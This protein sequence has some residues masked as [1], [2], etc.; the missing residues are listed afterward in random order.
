MRA[1]NLVLVVLVLLASCAT[2]A[3][4][5]DEETAA[6]QRFKG[7]A[8]PSVSGSP[9]SFSEAVED[10][11]VADDE[12][13]FIWEVDDSPLTT[14][15]PS[16]SA[17]IR[18]TILRNARSYLDPSRYGLIEATSRG[19]ADFI[20]HVRVDT[21]TEYSGYSSID[22]GTRRYTYRLED[23]SRGVFIS[24]DTLRFEVAHNRR[25]NESVILVADWTSTHRPRNANEP[26]TVA[27]VSGVYE[28]TMI[29]FRFDAAQASGSDDVEWINAEPDS[30]G[31]ITINRAEQYAVMGFD[32]D[33]SGTVETD[34]TKVETPIDV[35]IGDGLDSVS[36][37]YS[38]MRYVMHWDAVEGRYY[39]S[40]IDL[41]NGQSTA[42]EVV[43]I[44]RWYGR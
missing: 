3:S 12:V 28:I 27:P 17:T 39:L 25:E 18:Q 35:E 21:T 40:E 5:R 43:M 34:E 32:Y 9:A 41:L 14:A 30:R 6:W 16:L 36:W 44:E 20:L 1:S 10:A 2:D 26:E 4:Y 29:L 42:F 11:F 7:Q 31:L 37:Q 19:R 24:E 38:S 13:T 33:R 23:T 8:V 15:D 22:L